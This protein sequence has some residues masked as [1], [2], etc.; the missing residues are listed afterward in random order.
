MIFLDTNVLLYS[1]STDPQDEAK[2]QVALELLSRQDITL[3]VQVLQEFYVQSTRA[4]R[5]DALAHATA[6]GLIEA[7]MRYPIV[8]IDLDLLQAA[9]ELRTRY[10]WSYWD[11]AIVAAALSSNSQELLTEDMQHGQAVGPLLIRNPFLPG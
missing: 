8:P 6:V 11:S 10:N 1:I 7:W 5:V 2:R 4:S 3:S 9:L